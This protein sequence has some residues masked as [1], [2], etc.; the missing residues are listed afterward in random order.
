MTIPELLDR[1]A[2]RT[3][4]D[5]G[6]LSDGGYHASSDEAMADADALSHLAERWREIERLVFTQ[7]F[8]GGRRELMKALRVTQVT[9]ALRRSRERDL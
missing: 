1:A 8:S 3:A 9:R 6:R 5:A 2:E 7:K 4:A